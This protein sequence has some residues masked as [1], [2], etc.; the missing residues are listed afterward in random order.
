MKVG[1]SE[2][3]ITPDLVNH[4]RKLQLAGYS[5]RKYCSGIHDDLYARAVYFEG[6]TDDIRTHVLMI[7]CDILYLNGTFA[8]LIKKY[9]SRSI[10]IATENILISATHTHHGPDYSGIF[11]KGGH[12]GIMRGI[13]SPNPLPKE[14]FFLGKNLVKVAKDAYKNKQNAKL[15]ATQVHIHEKDRIII[16]RRD[17]FNY[18]KA[19]YPLTVIKLIKEN[20]ELLGL[21]LNYAC[22]GTVLPYQ[23]TLIT[24]DYVG[25]VIKTLEND[26]PELKGNIIYFNGPCGEI[27]PLTLTLKMKMEKFGPKGVKNRDIYL[28]RGTFNDAKHIGGTIARYV[29]KNVDNI[30]CYAYENFFSKQESICIPVK[31]YDYGSDIISAFRRLFYKRKLK[32]FALLKKGGLLKTT[33]FFK[34]DNSDIKSGA[35]VNTLIQVINIGTILIMA[36]PGEYFMELGN[37]VINY[38]KNIFP[39]KISF[40]IELAND[41][42]GYLYTIEAYREGGYESAFSVIPLGG[43]F[44]AMKLKQ[45]IRKNFLDFSI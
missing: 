41:S 18:N 14:L 34:V 23:N 10:P 38:A 43:R 1:F 27:N 17:I 16:N 24:A 45:L 12:L 13:I 8:N 21:I 3:I 9:I 28:Q 32:L 19:N 40:M 11:R 6:K 30:D 22:H 26:Y 44:I 5:P 7:V 25:Y 42:V 35:Y 36:V 29:L 2:I 4:K 20:G 31:D 33:I 39:S 37:E 15:G